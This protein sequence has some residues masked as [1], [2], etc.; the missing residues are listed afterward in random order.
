M[1]ER[2]AAGIGLVLIVEDD[3]V[4]RRVLQAMLARLGRP[5][6]TAASL[7]EAR[8]CLAD[9]RVTTVLLDLR[10][11]G[12]AG[13]DL[14]DSLGEGSRSCSLVLMSGCD[15]RTRAAT[16]KLAQACGV[17]VA[18]AL[19]K[20]IRDDELAALLR[21][22]PDGAPRRPAEDLPRVTADDIR[23]AIAAGHIKPQFQ[24]KI[25]LATGAPVGVEALA[26]WHSPLLGTIA[27]DVFVP[28]AEAGGETFALTEL[29]LTES[30]AACARWSRRHPDLTVAVNVPPSVIGPALAAA[31]THQL[32]RHGLPPS[33]LVLKITENR[34]V[35]D[36]LETAERLARLR[37]DGVQLSIDDFGTGYSSLVSLL[38]IP[39]NEIKLDRLF[40][41]NALRDPDADR[42]LRAVIAMSHEMG[43]R[44]V[45]EGID[46][47]EI[48]DR[49][50]RYGCAVGQGWLWSKAMSEA[51]LTAWLDSMEPRA[52]C[53]V[54]A[55]PCE[56]KH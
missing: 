5:C 51:Q 10:L 49:L 34:L 24:P 29:M 36:S 46:S 9:Q 33:S 11:D 18:G 19:G 38:R 47:V 2:T 35:S 4:Q 44:C 28:V 43:L 53:P 15:Q 26:R 52:A 20:P 48:R 30:L 25:A 37:I 42:I 45:A 1:V 39:F 31:V 8:A 17:R 41:S 23:L 21:M 27:P 16:V 40:V 13:L 22:S 32:K 50:A 12:E 6:L 14:L 55:A 56:R 54:D 7:R 3:V